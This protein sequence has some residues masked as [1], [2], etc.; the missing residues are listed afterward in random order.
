MVRALFGKP[1]NGYQKRCLKTYLKS[2]LTKD[3]RHFCL[4]PSKKANST[5]ANGCKAK[6]LHM[7]NEQVPTQCER[8]HDCDTQRQQHQL[9]GVCNAAKQPVSELQ[10]QQRLKAQLSIPCISQLHAQ[11][12]M[13]R[14]TK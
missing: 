8:M 2:D 1:K 4:F 6:L 3:A 10:N 11:R 13:R 12:G 7:N 14:P 9:S 5:I